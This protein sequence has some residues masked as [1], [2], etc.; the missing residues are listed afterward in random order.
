M[1]SLTTTWTKDVWYSYSL[2]TE[3]EVMNVNK[4]MY[5]DLDYNVLR[6]FKDIL[7][8]AALNRFGTIQI[9]K[10]QFHM[11]YTEGVEEKIRNTIID[12]YIR[13]KTFEPVFTEEDIL[14]Y[15]SENI[16]PTS[17]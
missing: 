5:K 9:N 7:W 14:K 10:K 4:I 6:Q 11:I 3:R 15:Y 2:S 1:V 12:F 16:T 17:E 8:N 13:F